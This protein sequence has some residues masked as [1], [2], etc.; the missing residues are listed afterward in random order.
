VTDK[1]TR[2]WQ[3]LA[4]VLVGSFMAVLDTTIVNV[5]LPSIGQGAHASSDALEWVVSGYALTFGLALVPAGRMG[6]R[7]G[8]KRLFLAGLILFTVA[9]V[10][11]GISASSAELVVARLVQGLG[12]GIYYPAISAIIQRLFT[13]RE[14]SRA[15]GYL[16]GVVGISTAVGPLLGGLIISL[17]GVQ[18][19][20]RWVFL[21]NLF[22]GIAE[23]PVAFRLLPKRQR[24]EQHRLDWLGNALLTL[25]LL[26]L[27]IPLVEGRVSGWPAWSW[28]MI[29]LS[30]PAAA[31]LVAWEARLSRRGGE[32]VIQLALLRRHR[33]FGMGQ[34]LALLYFGGFTSLFFTL[35]IMWQ[36]GLGRSALQTGLLVLPFALGS[37][38]TASNSYRFS[39][40]FGR[41]AVL[42]GI[43]GMFAGQALILLVLRLSGSHPGF[44][45][46]VG[47]LLLAG[48]G[49][50][51][52]IAPNQDFVLAS[53]PREQAGTAGGALITAQRL[54]AAI[55]IA[56]V[57][58][59]LFGSG[60]SGSSASASHPMPSLV[61]SAQDATVV[62]LCF[63]VAA[64]ACAFGLPRRLAG[65][66]AET[67]QDG[68]PEEAREPQPAA[69][70]RGAALRGAGV[71][72]LPRAA[73]AAAPGGLVP[74]APDPLLRRGAAP[75][76]VHLAAPHREVEAF[77]PHRASGADPLCPGDLFDAH[78]TGRDREEKVGVGGQAGARRA[79][80][81]GVLGHVTSSTRGRAFR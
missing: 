24:P 62:N 36:E 74:P 32:P 18:E 80:F 29:G 78:A 7:V 8:Y 53:V 30:V 27:L 5:A 47:P 39:R 68:E 20:W 69:R 59:A 54:G 25:V 58:T 1:N 34:A 56:A 26:L 46:L 12:A 75:D 22:I 72:R 35:S 55:G 63:I 31:L 42:G 2:N 77:L 9:S 61:H 81:G 66:G 11:C 28:L 21:V 52:V 50:G 6:D 73:G 45:P 70:R 49:S 40:R 71:R 3:I 64:L 76:A 65:N 51:L 33:S 67:G 37:L 44:W 13:G 15:F 10:G 57:G 16:G 4:I 43:C 23:I 14:R 17:A 38:S 60:S 48:L 79:P 41:K 19:G